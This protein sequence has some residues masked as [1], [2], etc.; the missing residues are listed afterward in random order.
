MVGYLR[1]ADARP[2]ARAPALARRLRLDA[3]SA[4]CGR[5]PPPARAPAL[6]RRLRLDAP[7]A[8]CG[9]PPP[10]ARAPALARRLQPPAGHTSLGQV[11]RAFSRAALG[12]ARGRPG[13]GNAKGFRW[14]T[15]PA[16]HGRCESGRP[17]QPWP[18][19]AGIQPRSTWPGA[20]PAGQ[21][22]RLAGRQMH[23]AHAVV[24]SCPAAVVP[25]PATPEAARAG[26]GGAHAKGGG[27][28]TKAAGVPAPA[29]PE[30]A[31]A[32]GRALAPHSVA[33]LANSGFAVDNDAAGH[34]L[35]TLLANCR[36]AVDM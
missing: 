4:R 6:A 7:S 5:P 9:R 22:P 35:I 21:R 30:A 16:R 25:A 28:L 17:H 12:Q 24:T 11:L 13:A 19:A 3:P 14:S 33:L 8:R 27:L 20:R 10:P 26:G 1:F 15:L 32:G 34:S 29:T 23:R 36:R 2:P 31:R 18:R